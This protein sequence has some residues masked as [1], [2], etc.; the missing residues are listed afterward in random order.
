ML[1][2][3]GL[4]IF[5]IL[6]S[7]FPT[8]VQAIDTNANSR[9][10][11]L[12]PSMI[13]VDST[14]SLGG[15]GASWG[16][17]YRYLQDALIAASTLPS[18][19][20]WVAKGT[21]YP[22]ED[23][24]TNNASKGDPN[25]SFAM[26]NN[27]ALYGGFRNVHT[28]L[29]DRDWVSNR[30]ILSGDIDPVN[31]SYHVIRNDNSQASP[32][33]GT[34]VLS[35][36]IIEGG[37]GDYSIDPSDDRNF[38]GGMFNRYSSPTVSYCTFRKNQAQ[39]GAAIFNQ[40]ASNPSISNSII[41]FNVAWDKG[42]A[43]YNA[44]SQPTL[45]NCTITQNKGPNTTFFSEHSIYNSKADIIIR[46]CILWENYNEIE[47]LLSTPDVSHSIVQGGYLGG[48]S[49][50][51][52]DPLFMDPLNDFSIK[53]C[54]PAINNGIN[55]GSLGS[56]D[57]ALDLRLRHGTI[58]IGAYEFETG[59]LYVDH[60]A[61]GADD[62]T[63]WT[64]AFAKLQDALRTLSLCESPGQIWIARGTYY[65][66]EGL[67][68]VD[69]FRTST[70]KMLPD[71][72]MY[73][74]FV[75]GETSVADRNWEFNLTILSGDIDQNDISGSIDFNAYHVINNDY[76]ASN[77][78]TATARLDGIVVADG[79]ADL[80]FV[81]DEGGGMKN[82]NSSPT[83][84]NC[85]FANNSAN[86]GG[87]MHN[88]N[89]NLHIINCKFN[90]NNAVL[91]GGGIRHLRAP[92]TLTDCAFGYGFAGTNIGADG[93]GGVACKGSLSRLT[94]NNCSF[95][96]NATTGRGGA[97]VIQ[98]D[99]INKFDNCIFRRNEGRFSGAVSTYSRLDLSECQFDT[100]QVIPASNVQ[101][102]F[103]GGAIEVA[104][105]ST[106]MDNCIFNGNRTDQYGGAIAVTFLGRA[107]VSNSS[108]LN[109]SADFWVF[110][111]PD[112]IE[113]RGGAVYIASEAKTTLENCDF[114]EN[115]AALKGGAVF[116]ESDETLISNS[117]FWNN[118]TTEFGHAV[119][120][121]DANTMMVNCVFANNNVTNVSYTIYNENLSQPLLKNSIIWKYGVVD[122]PRVIFDESG[123]F[124]VVNNC[125]IQGGWI[126]GT[127]VLDLDPK[128]ADAIT[129]DLR[130]QSC[131]PAIDFGSDSDNLNS[132][133]LDGSPR[134]H[135]AKSSTTDDIDLGPY[136]FQGSYTMTCNC[137]LNL[138]VSMYINSGTY[139]ASQTV[140][141]DG[142]IVIG[143]SVLFSAG[144]CI[145]L[146]PNFQ[147]PANAV[148]E[149]VMDG[150][151]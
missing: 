84:V 100:N 54:S 133:D 30:T 151:Q 62:G 28:Q 149:I 64:D 72:Q 131:S 91:E 145:E 12:A 3:L 15:N 134:I 113:P 33:D 137:P 96:E 48:S 67:G 34:A 94:M 59:V 109:N 60:G 22:D 135:D 9:I 138:P 112:F 126:S 68:Q 44:L 132:L 14:A 86:Y 89:S 142:L 70:F 82:V 87:G 88:D 36:F 38:G 55:A 46:N 25:A 122:P 147:V 85:S 99:G 27:I 120:N 32:L 81:E 78:L 83:I 7:V 129:G 40:F 97:V 17:A 79:N 107:Y 127:D 141:S 18:A 23:E 115:F 93:G 105:D 51:G 80:D 65:P 42:D 41:S 47:N 103:T 29:S 61:V 24:A 77:P 71:V 110:Q 143:S 136:E 49:I 53:I 76:S 13:Y 35:G 57:Y 58:D 119:Y 66:D 63:S 124:S 73:G 140:T 150:C 26:L 37:Y 6:A 111:D 75:T 45:L 114:S 21:Y 4:K 8:S 39:L 90:Q 92:L 98:N 106:S 50:I 146:M 69:G 43:L 108:F 16:T 95:I 1:K 118:T 116:S 2:P 74:G 148:F 121:H 101:I 11:N 19:D 5:W 31:D 104:G 102:H 10:S 130:L 117:R 123:S 56:V 52:D 139:S 20:I 125:I 128:L 144:D